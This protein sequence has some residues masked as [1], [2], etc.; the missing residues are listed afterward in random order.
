MRLFRMDFNP[1]CNS[2]NIE[3]QRILSFVFKVADF[4]AWQG[5]PHKFFSSVGRRETRVE[6]LSKKQE[7][8]LN[9]WL[10]VVCWSPLPFWLVTS[11]AELQLTRLKFNSGWKWSR[12]HNCLN[13][14]PFFCQTLLMRNWEFPKGDLISRREERSKKKVCDYCI[15]PLCSMYADV[16][17]TRVNKTL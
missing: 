11:L 12:I 4:L 15:R 17:S 10:V 7:P 5:L 16:A 8:I 3:C 1:L 9:K 14:F 6:L 2:W 13:S